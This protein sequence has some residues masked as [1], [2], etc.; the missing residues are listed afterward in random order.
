DDWDHFASATVL[1]HNA[2]LE[3]LQAA[4]DLKRKLKF[5]C[6]QTELEKIEG[7][8]AGVE[9]VTGL[10]SSLDTTTESE[11]VLEATQ[12]NVDACAVPNGPLSIT[13]TRV[14]C[15]RRLCETALAGLRARGGPEPRRSLYWLVWQLCDIYRRETG[16]AVRNPLIGN[17]TARPQAPCER[18]V[19]GAV[20]ALQPSK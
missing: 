1:D 7:L 17:Y 11:L 18:F 14:E 9:R 19:V 5:N 6:R 8:V 10:L 16:R 13:L 15:L 2:W 20:E 12:T 4:T 3:L